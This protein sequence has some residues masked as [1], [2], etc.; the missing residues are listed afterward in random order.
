[1]I[2]KPI[3]PPVIDDYIQITY[4]EIYKKDFGS[5]FFNDDNKYDV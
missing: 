2:L 5:L 4:K 1:M 3:K